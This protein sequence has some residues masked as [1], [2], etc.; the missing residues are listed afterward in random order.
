MD[1]VDSVNSFHVA[2][3]GN[4]PVESWTVV[5]ALCGAKPLLSA[6]SYNTILNVQFESLLI[7]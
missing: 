2:S 5:K 3:Q 4:A 6:L 7:L 1:V